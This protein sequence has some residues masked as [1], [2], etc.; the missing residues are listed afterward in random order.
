VVSA[1]ESGFVEYWQ[2]REPW[3]PPRNVL[4]L[5]ELKSST[6]LYEFKKVLAHVTSLQFFANMFP[7]Q[8]HPNFYIIL[9]GLFTFCHALYLRPTNS[10]I[11][12]YH[13]QNDS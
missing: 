6:D 8:K 4:G 13:W 10:N 7:D 9:T 2:P 1:D 5:W 3:E 11:Q 12:F